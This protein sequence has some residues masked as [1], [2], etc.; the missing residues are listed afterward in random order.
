MTQS[1]AER[2]RGRDEE[3]FDRHRCAVLAAP[4]LAQTFR[5]S[6]IRVLTGLA[7]LVDF[8][9]VRTGETVTRER[10]G[11]NTSLGCLCAQSTR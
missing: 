7:D 4:A 9:F 10:E 3:T 11:R 5:Q 2:A 6:A 1:W 8:G